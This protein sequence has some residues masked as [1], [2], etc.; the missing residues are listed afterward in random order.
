[1]SAWNAR[2]DETSWAMAS[3]GRRP[4][5]VLPPGAEP[6]AVDPVGL[7][8][9]SP[10]L[11]H[12]AGLEHRAQ[13]FDHPPRGVA[14]AAVHAR[15][16][17]RLVGRFVDDRV[18]VD[19]PVAG[20]LPAVASYS[21]MRLVAA[22]NSRAA[23]RWR[24]PFAAGLPL[25]SRPA[26]ER[27]RPP[28]ETAARSAASRGRRSS[29][30]TSDTAPRTAGP[31]GRAGRRDGRPG[32]GPRP[33]PH[34]PGRTRE[35]LP[36]NL[37][38]RV[39]LEPPATCCSSSPCRGS[40]STDLPVARRSRTLLLFQ[41]SGVPSSG[42][43]ASFSRISRLGGASGCEQR[44]NSRAASAIHEQHGDVLQQMYRRD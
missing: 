40:N 37:G 41:A 25:R 21:R 30:R 10:R 12:A 1:M 33:K 35:Q 43:P 19:R 34:S 22:S 15:V 6:A 8:R 3:A 23:A 4:S 11:P 14:E 16:E 18:G 31:T 44:S 17:R 32:S 26:A 13:P 29:A 24:H 42:R 20:P 9:E 39:A 38:L 36:A 7:V 5:G 2:S 28:A 27:R